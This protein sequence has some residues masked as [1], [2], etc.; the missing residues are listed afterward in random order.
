MNVDNSVGDRPPVAAPPSAIMEPEVKGESE[1]EQVRGSVRCRGTGGRKGG[2]SGNF[3]ANVT[4]ETRNS[5][6]NF[7]FSDVLA[8][9]VGG[10]QAELATLSPFC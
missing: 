4:R 8:C 2:A 7:R 9:F 6:H 10:N 1:R 5:T 3:N